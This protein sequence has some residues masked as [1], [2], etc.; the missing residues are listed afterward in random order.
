VKP[1]NRI[2]QN[3][4]ILPS[5]KLHAVRKM[6]GEKNPAGLDLALLSEG[7]FIC[8]GCYRCTQ[9]CPSGINLQDLWRSSEQD[10][11]R[12]G[13]PQP[14]VW[15]RHRRA[16][17]WVRDLAQAEPQ[18]KK[19]A[20]E[21]PGVYSD[22]LNRPEAFSACIQCAT[23]SSVCPVV[24]AVDDAQQDLDFTPQQ[25]MN[26]LRLNLKD[27][28]RGTRMVWNCVT[29][30]QCQ[31]NCPQGIRV[32]DIFYEL[33]NSAYQIYAPLQRDTNRPNDRLEGAMAGVHR[34]RL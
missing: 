8:T 23:C 15:I 16:D 10:L 19:A 18:V 33:R 6:A 20:V 4:L 12:R 25:V 9:L 11:I 3:P 27:I 29:C 30:Y 17:E 21:I 31:E 32:A 7:S 26:L 1:A 14:H 22:A 5:E 24:A 34:D 2:L 28:A 13:F